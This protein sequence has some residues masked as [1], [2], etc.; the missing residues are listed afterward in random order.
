MVANTKSLF[1]VPPLHNSATGA[2]EVDLNTI[3]SVESAER[4]ELQSKKLEWGKRCSADPRT[5]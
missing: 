4:S 1:G 3:N 5:S 2:G